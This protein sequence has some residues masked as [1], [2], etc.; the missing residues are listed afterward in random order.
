MRHQEDQ[1]HRDRMARQHADE[2]AAMAEAASKMQDALL[3]AKRGARANTRPVKK[4]S[5][6][7]A[8]KKRTKFNQKKTGTEMTDEEIGIQMSEMNLTALSEGEAGSS[9]AKKKKKKKKG[10]LGG[11]AGNAV[12]F[13]DNTSIG[14]DV[15]DTTQDLAIEP[16]PMYTNPSN[17]QASEPDNPVHT[18]SRSTFRKHQ[19]EEGYTFYEDTDTGETVWDLPDGGEVVEF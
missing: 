6:K 18:R 4:G 2:L 16:L 7:Q 10:R 15:Y 14:F 9:K 17:L 11:G 5:K 13:E 12:S 8:A 1:E 19:S 3:K